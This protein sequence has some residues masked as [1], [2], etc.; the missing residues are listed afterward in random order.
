[1]ST[2]WPSPEDYQSAVQ[3]PTRYLSDT[4]LHSAQ[5]ETRKLGALIAPYPRS[6][7]F[8]A[9]YKFTKQHQAYALKVFIKAQPDREQRYQLIDQHLKQQ[10]A[11]SG[12][13]S[14]GYDPQGIL[15]K[16]RRY[17]TLVMDW[18]EGQTLDN[19][20]AE[21]FR[22]N[23]QI[24][25]GRLCQAWAELVLKLSAQRVAHGDLQ[26]G[27]ILVLPGG[28]LRL[29]DYDGLFVPTMRQAG[30]RAAEIG[31]PAY[32]HPQRNRGYF[33]ERLDDFAALV[34][35]LCLASVDRERW[36]RY[37]TDDNCLILKESDLVH[38]ERS[39]VFAELS[40]SP[41][42][43]VKK[44]ANMLK[45]AASSGLDAIPPFNQVVA[46]S[47][48]KQVLNPAWGPTPSSRPGPKPL[49]KCANC[50]TEIRSGDVYCPRCDTAVNGQ[51]PPIAT[52]FEATFSQPYVQQA[53]PS[54]PG[55]LTSRQ[56]EILGLMVV[57]DTDDKIAEKLQLQ[58]EAVKVL[59]SEMMTNLG[60]STRYGLFSWARRQGL[61]P[62]PLT[63]ANVVSSVFFTLLGAVLTFVGFSG[64]YTQWLPV[65]VGIF[66]IAF[67]TL[68]HSMRFLW[69]NMGPR[70][71]SS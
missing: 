3:N 54:V 25:N 21:A 71:K 12:L 69:W 47:A 59:I 24:A 68:G 50:G 10:S 57:G 34:I 26:H 49:V 46:D 20:L 60:V 36:Q 19:Y 22:H 65:S 29:V 40:Q 52:A 48:I 6:G 38:P 51:P 39:P 4:R 35:L 17:P 32:Q 23:D 43:P 8:G 53:A 64:T 62:P 14:F 33:D 18:V 61:R 63:T 15:V 27:N 42:A 7:N 67:V 28:A 2:V 13:V 5:V 66:L 70:N 44:L 56:L 31:L 11:S 45:A 9:V 58:T 55:T 37:H 1:M 16:G 30:L 41:D